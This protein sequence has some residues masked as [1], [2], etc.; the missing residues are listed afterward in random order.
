VPEGGAVAT[1]M[2]F[3][4]F[5]SWGFRLKAITSSFLTT[6]I[7]T[8]LVRYGLMAIALVVLSFSEDS[9]GT[10]RLI[11]LVVSVLIALAVAALVGVLRSVRFARS[12]GRLTGRVMRPVYRIARKPPLDD[13][14][15]RTE[16]FRDELLTLVE[17]RWLRLTLT[18]ILSQ[19]SACL[20]LGVA[21]RL[22]GLDASLIPISLVV[23]AYASMALASLVAPTPG[24][25][26]VAEVMLLAVLTY[27][28]PEQYDT[29]VMAAILLFR[30]ATWLLPIPV[31][32]GCYVVWRSNHSW[33]LT[34]AERDAR[35]SATSVRV[36]AP[37]A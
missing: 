31:G 17:R 12:L 32:A 24:G 29:A 13:W 27:N 25:L 28:L 36:P 22:Q 20:V 37:A 4:M 30:M 9:S 15:D 34:E 26:G 6:G 1:G 2:Q 35:A 16:E 3:A 5:R 14:D 33:R 18:M 23:V 19:L 10:L 8:N 11:A 7:W 21:L